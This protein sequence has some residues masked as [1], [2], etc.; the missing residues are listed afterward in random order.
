MPLTLLD[1][2]C[3][4]WGG[5]V[6][7]TNPATI[8]GPPPMEVL[9]PV[10][11]MPGTLPPPTSGGLLITV[12]PGAKEDCVATEEVEF[13]RVGLDGRILPVIMLSL[14]LWAALD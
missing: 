12:V 7:G 4:V 2:L 14:G 5:V 9:L 3:G 11:A 13:D 10:A 8:L 6:I 1:V